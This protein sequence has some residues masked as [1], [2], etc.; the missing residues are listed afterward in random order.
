MKKKILFLALS[1]GVLVN[2]YCQ[3]KAELIQ[4]ID[5]LQKLNDQY[6]I[7][8]D[9]T[10]KMY[11]DLNL[12]VSTFTKTPE[13]FYKCGLEELNKGNF[14]VS[15]RIFA[16]II[17][18]FPSDVYAKNSQAQ[19]E[20]LNQ[21]S[22]ENINEILKN[23]SKLSLR[24]KVTFL[25]KAKSQQYLNQQDSV[26]IATIF[27]Q[28]NVE[29][30]SEKFVIEKNDSMQSCKFYQ[31]IRDAKYEEGS[32]SYQLSLYIV[33]NY[34]GTKYFRLE[35]G[36]VGKDWIFYKEVIIRGDNGTQI[37]IQC[38]YPEKKSDNGSYGVHEWSDNF[39]QKSDEAKIVSIANCKTISVRF[40]G[41]YSKTFNMSEDQLKAFKEIVLKYNKL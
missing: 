26:K 24:E 40:V 2:L 32:Q 28:L 9:S 25:S 21:K 15:Y 41:Q 31:S 39:I 30:Q 22:L 10:T 12:F 20:M 6:R 16:N 5:S 8:L 14:A 36:F 4:K 27:N 19:I 38:E 18:S 13:Y 29:F 7:K 33:K 3:K 35:T 37:N 17:Q 34:V 23:N 1:F 11:N